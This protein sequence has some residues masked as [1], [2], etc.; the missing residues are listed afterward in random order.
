MLIA[1]GLGC[2]RLGDGLITGFQLCPLEAQDLG[3]DTVGF[4]LMDCP[5]TFSLFLHWGVSSKPPISPHIQPYP[6]LSYFADNFE[7]YFVSGAE[8]PKK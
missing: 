8:K 4:S 5:G 1:E 2:Q 7:Q 3:G 6:L